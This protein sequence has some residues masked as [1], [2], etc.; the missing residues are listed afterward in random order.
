MPKHRRFRK[1]LNRSVLRKQRLEV[2]YATTTRL[3][4]IRLQ[5]MPTKVAWAGT[6]V[7]EMPNI[8]LDGYDVTLLASDSSPE[9]KVAWPCFLMPE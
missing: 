7:S 5:Y 6:L 1:R 3:H 2:A 4:A 9:Q 8:A